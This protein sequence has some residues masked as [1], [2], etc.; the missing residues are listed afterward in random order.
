MTKN[1][2]ESVHQSA[3]EELNQVRE[4]NDKLAEN[5]RKLMSQ[6]RETLA[7]GK[8]LTPQEAKILIDRIQSAEETLNQVS[9][10]RKDK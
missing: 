3:I 8:Y 6:A 4:D 10:V 7:R 9:K 5:L 1:Y 2:I